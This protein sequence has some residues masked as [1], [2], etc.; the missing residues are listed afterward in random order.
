LGFE[1][2]AQATGRGAGV[3]VFQQLK[4]KYL[5]PFKG[6]IQAVRLRLDGTTG[7]RQ[8]LT[9]RPAIQPL[10][11]ALTGRR[12]L[13]LWAERN[14]LGAA[15]ADANGRFHPTPAPPGPPPIVDGTF[16]RTPDMRT[17]G[18]WAIATWVRG[19]QVRI[20]LRQF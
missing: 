13:V 8:T 15:L 5:S 9:S 12:V 7:S 1:P 18:R 16:R 2:W 11:S 10:V 20:S 3:L 17:A 19:G 4:N 6:P 14:R